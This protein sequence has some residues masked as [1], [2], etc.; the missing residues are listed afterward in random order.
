MEKNEIVRECSEHVSSKL[1]NTPT[2]SKQSYIDDKILEL[3]MRNPYRLAS[4]IPDTSD[5]QHQFLY[6]IILKLRKL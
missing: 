2:V 3:V 4:T 1:N 6:R 5:G